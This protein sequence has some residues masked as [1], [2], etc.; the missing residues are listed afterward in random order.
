MHMCMHQA[1]HFL[2]HIVMS[3]KSFSSTKPLAE[4]APR[5]RPPSTT[6]S[7]LITDHCLLITTDPESG[8]P[9]LSFAI[10]YEFVT[11]H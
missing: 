1:T 4:A 7:S 3:L 5:S 6:N 8:G 9:A 2:A 10:Y 11:D